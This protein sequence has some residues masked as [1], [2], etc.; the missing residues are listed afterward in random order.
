M[1]PDV[2]LQ[3]Q[4]DKGQFQGIFGDV[5]WFV[6]LLY[7]LREVKVVHGINVT[8][9]IVKSGIPIRVGILKSFYDIS[10]FDFV[11][12]S[13][14]KKLIGVKPRN[15]EMEDIIH[16]AYSEGFVS[17]DQM[18]KTSIDFSI[19]V[20]NFGVIR[21]NYARSDASL[22]MN[23]RYLDY[24]IPDFETVGYPDHYVNFFA[25]IPQVKEI[26]LKDKVLAHKTVGKNGLI[27]HAGPT[28]SG[29]TTAIASEIGYLA[30]NISGII[31]TYEEPVEYRF[32]TDLNVLQYEVDRDISRSEIKRHALRNTPSV[33]VWGEIREQSEFKDVLD[34]ATRGHLV[35]TTMHAGNA[36]EVLKFAATALTESEIANFASLMQAIVVHRLMINSKGDPVTLFEMLIN[37]KKL[38]T[39]LLDIKDPLKLKGLYN[40]MYDANR[41]E[42]IETFMSFAESALIRKQQKLLDAREYQEFIETLQY[43]ARG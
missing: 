3:N 2:M 23:I 11:T 1:I 28:G 42:K 6:N 31:I 40:A 26:K 25:S 43:T 37:N 19:A 18:Q 32:I 39:L 38:S 17:K 34:I 12:E 36:Y 4:L 13:I 21:I 7:F 20:M 30:S 29:K 22:V 8:D 24:M 14:V 15:N 27:I 5:P 9:A 35:I 10:E 16:K 33:I 41:G